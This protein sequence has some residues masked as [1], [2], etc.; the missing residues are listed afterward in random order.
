MN[1]VAVFITAYNEG[2]VLGSVLSQ[3]NRD[4]DVYVIDDGS[5]DETPAVARK[6]HASVIT[7]SINLGQGMALLTAFKL[8]SQKDYDIVIEMDGDG[9]HD[10]G[11]IRKFIQKIAETD[12][13]IVAG[14]RILGS[15]YEGAPFARRFFLRPLTW[16]LNKLTGYNISDAMCGFRIFKGKSLKKV[17]YL[18][19]DMLEPEYI[20]SEM[21][22]KFAKA[23]LTASEVPIKM[24]G[25]KYGFSYKGLFRYGWGVISTII[26]TKLET[27]RYVQ[28]TKTGDEDES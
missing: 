26:R 16:I 24:A 17:E 18:F 6:H 1:K 4:Y 22:I 20:A 28:M 8:L 12:T 9:Q 19:D 21:W 25:R 5:T 11:D 10:P 3:I 27:Y 2:K 13:D 7:H 14:S 23:G 15:D